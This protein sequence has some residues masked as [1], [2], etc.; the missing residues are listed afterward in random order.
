[1][2]R[3]PVQCVGR[4]DWERDSVLVEGDDGDNGIDGI[5]KVVTVVLD[6]EEFPVTG[7]LEE[8]FSEQVPHLMFP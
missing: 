6:G 8:A 1:M 4:N 2:V 3:T 7:R 5:R